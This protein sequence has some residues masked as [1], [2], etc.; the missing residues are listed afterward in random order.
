MSSFMSLIGWAFLPDLAT[1]WVQTIYYGIVIR[2]GDPKPRPGTP[3]YAEHRR[4]IHIL[5]VSAYLLY[6]IF[7]AD[8]EIRQAGSFY[9]DLGLTPAA[10]EREVKSRFRRLA[11]LYHPDKVGTTG[12]GGSAPQ[13]GGYDADFFMRLK[14]ASETLTDPARA[15]LRRWARTS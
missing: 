2:A 7:E 15:S 13:Q 12:G 1:N 14:V 10:T 11:A 9:S 4:R 5:V 6:T 8:R 3:R